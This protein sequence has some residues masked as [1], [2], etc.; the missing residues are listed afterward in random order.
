MKTLDYIDEIKKKFTVTE[1]KPVSDYRV[2]QLLEISKQ[3]VSN[4][5][6]RGGTFDDETAIK[7]GALL[8]MPGYI[9]ITDMNCERARKKHNPE[10]TRAW[11][12]IAKKLSGTAAVIMMTTATMLPG[13]VEAS[14]F[15]IT[16]FTASFVNNIYYAAFNLPL[17]LCRFSVIY[18]TQFLKGY[19]HPPV[20]IHSPQAHC[21]LCV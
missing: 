7:A 11:D 14:V 3:T 4:Y 12:E 10:V 20:T 18:L 9:V 21:P 17:K 6:N 5:V 19:I 13:Q 15:N 1:G 16:S 2:A 8:D